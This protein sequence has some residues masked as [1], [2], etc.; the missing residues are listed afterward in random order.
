MG[1]AGRWN[2]HESWSWTGWHQRT[3]TFSPET[4]LTEAGA[5]LS[6]GEDV[7]T[8]LLYYGVLPAKDDGEDRQLVVVTADRRT[9]EIVWRF[10]RLARDEANFPSLAAAFPGVLWIEREIWERTGVI[11]LGHPDLRAILHPEVT[12]PEPVATGAGIFHLPLGPVRADVSESGYFLFDTIGE[13]IMHMQPQLFFKH[14]AVERLAEGMVPADALLLAERVSGTSTVAHATAFCRAVEQALGRPAG[15]G[16]ERERIVFGEL[17]RLYNHAHDFAQLASATGMTVGQAQLTR[18]KEECLRLNGD[19]TGSRYLRGAVLL[20]GP[21]S[22]DWERAAKELPARLRAIDSRLKHFIELLER[23]PTFID[24]LRPTGIVRREWAQAYGVVGPVARACGFQRDARSDYLGDLYAPAGFV[25]MTAG[26]SFG[27]A[28][29][30][31][32]VRVLEWDVSLRVIGHLLP[33][34][35]DC[36]Q[37]AADTLQPSGGAGIGVAESPRGRTCHIVLISDGRIRTWGIRAASAWNWP[38]F[39]LAT[40]NG[41]IQTDFPIIDAS[42]GLSYAGHD[43]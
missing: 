6:S 37:G 26:D 25:C 18:I 16:T 33:L 4:A 38:V 27:D 28:Y 36:A 29:S 23:T 3:Q 9:R 21:S 35:A 2:P 5:A 12:L 22:V 11:P 10:G 41:N 43:R 15:E 34:L 1:D 14:R 39:G 32:R 30:R 31:F 40:A 13:Q 42:F 7:R 24:R 8:E 20:G 19:L 17:E